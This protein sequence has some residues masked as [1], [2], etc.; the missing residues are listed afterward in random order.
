MVLVRGLLAFV[1]GWLAFRSRVTGVYLSII[2][3]AMTYALLLAF[4]RNEMGFGGNNGLTDFK[5][6]LGFDLQSD[7]TRAGLFMRLGLALGGRFLILCR[8]IVTS[9]LAGNRDG[10]RCAMRRAGRGSSAT[11]WRDTSSSS[12]CC[13]R[14]WR[15]SPAR[16]TSAGGHH[17]PERVLAAELHRDRDL[18]GGRRAR[19][20]IGAVIGAILVNWRESRCFTGWLPESGCSCLARSSNARD[21][22]P[23]ER[24]LG[25]LDSVTAPFSAESATVWTAQPARD[26]PQPAE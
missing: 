13:R 20:L 1:F 11:G 24:V 21:A 3:Q 6:V 9:R 2:T 12:S 18:G 16:S 4:F 23:A 26:A 7:E 8:W 15:A 22:V 14:C 17:Q 5:D 25:G 19:A 10:Q